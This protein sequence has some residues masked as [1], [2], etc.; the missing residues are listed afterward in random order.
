M[1]RSLSARH[2]HPGGTGGAARRAGGLGSGA[3]GSSG[4]V[5]CGVLVISERGSGGVAPSCTALPVLSFGAMPLEPLEALG[6]ALPNGDGAR[7][8]ASMLARCPEAMPSLG[9][10]GGSWLS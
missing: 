6:G 9:C 10:G 2:H 3:N 7:T 4:A 8:P 1:L 5:R